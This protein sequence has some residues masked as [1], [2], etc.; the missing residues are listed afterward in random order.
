[1]AEGFVPASGK[2][3]SKGLVVLALFSM[4]IFGTSFWGILIAL[5]GFPPV[6]MA[7]LR[8]LVASIT[9][10][11]VL[12]AFGYGWLFTD[13]KVFVRGGIHHKRAVW[14]IIAMSVFGSVIPNIL[15]NIGLLMMDP[16]S[17]ST[18]AALIQ[19][20]GPIF[21]IFLA[22]MVLGERIDKWKFLGLALVIPAT[23]VLTTYTRSGFDLTSKEAIGGLLNLLTAL[24]YSVSSMFLKRSLD[25]G[26]QPP[27]LIIMNGLWAA[28]LTAPILGLFYLAGWEQVPRISDMTFESV[29]ALFYISFGIYAVTGLLWYRVYQNDEVSRVVFY[30]F[31]LPVFSAAMGYALLGERLTW[32]QIA[33]GLAVLA[34]VGISQVKYRGGR[35]KR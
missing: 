9:L 15:Q 20:G 4:A 30:A 29:L 16:G 11:A 31:L 23:L 35:G 13:L 27:R 19:G 28:V 14:M 18:L 10:I 1:M 25:H 22:A 21:T 26:G 3:S 32:V 2:V 17:T 8:P 34:G 12:L 7:F 6:T 24:C 5:K 33:A